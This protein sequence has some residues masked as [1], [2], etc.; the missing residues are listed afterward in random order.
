MN[1]IKF[2]DKYFDLIDFNEMSKRGLVE[3]INREILHPIGLALCYDPDTGESEG[4]IVSPD[5]EWEYRD[6]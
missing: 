1:K 6:E 3:R 4:A 5:G 2:G